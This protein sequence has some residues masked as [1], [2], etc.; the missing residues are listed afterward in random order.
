V[1]GSFTITFDPTV[2]VV[3]A[4]TTIT[5]NSVNISPGAFAPFFFYNKSFQGGLLT[6]CSSGPVNNNSCAVPPGTNGFDIQ[7]HNLQSSPTFDILSYA[8]SSVTNKIFQSGNGAFGRAPP[9]SLRHFPAHFLFSQAVP[10]CW[11]SWAGE[12]NER[13]KNEKAWHCT[14]SH[15]SID[16][17]VCPSS[18]R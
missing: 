17:W 10:H 18:A 6:V 16:L 11:A 8:T 9:S 1:I 13:G 4:A 15:D 14:W 5:I 2:T 12:G 7:L 3:G